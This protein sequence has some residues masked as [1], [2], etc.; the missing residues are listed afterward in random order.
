MNYTVKTTSQGR[1]FWMEH[2]GMEVGVALDFGIRVVHLS[3]AGC[4]NLYY[5]QPE[6]RSDGFS[7]PDGWLLYGG[8]RMWLAPESDD[9]YY[10]DNSPVTFAVEENAVTF[11]QLPDPVMGLEKQLRLVLTDGGIRAEH[12]HKNITDRPIIGASWGVNTLDGGGRAEIPFLG[13]PA[14]DYTP[15][16]VVSLWADTNLHDPRL[17]FDREH[18]TATYMDVEGYLKLGIYSK[19][20]KAEFYNKGQKF[21]LGFAVL[22]ME[23]LPDGGC[24]FELY[25]CRKFVELEPLGASAIIAPGQCASHWETWLVEKE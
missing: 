2:H 18:L 12:S 4:E 7:T 20:G 10:P 11:T 16:R 24:N 5:T 6:D 8:H 1:V 22:P 3:A 19:A 13:A 14:G 17:H 23:D 21:T 9:S 15:R 25:M